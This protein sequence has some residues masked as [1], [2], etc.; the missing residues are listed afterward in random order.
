MGGGAKEGLEND[1]KMGGEEAGEM[2]FFPLSFPVLVHP[3]RVHTV[4]PDASESTQYTRYDGIIDNG[5]YGHE[6]KHCTKSTI[7]FALDK[8]SRVGSKGIG[9][10]AGRINQ[11]S[12]DWEA[13]TGENGGQTMTISKWLEE[14]C[15]DGSRTRSK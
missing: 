5:A 11:G 2:D 1:E 15:S 12:Q 6:M 8:A 4:P 10:R 9:S 3:V 7:Q 13:G 14:R